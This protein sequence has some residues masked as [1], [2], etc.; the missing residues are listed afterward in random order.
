MSHMGSPLAMHIVSDVH[1]ESGS[2]VGSFKLPAMH[3]F[4]AE[5]PSVASLNN[6]AAHPTPAV[7][8]I[9]G[10]IHGTCPFSSKCYIHSYKCRWRGLV[11]ILAYIPVP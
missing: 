3:E 11:G 10:V 7:G 6:I 5:D 2:V 9:P 8:D 1:S 4:P